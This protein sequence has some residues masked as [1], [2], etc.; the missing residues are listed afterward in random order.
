MRFDE[1]AHCYAE[2]AYVQREMADW[3][4]EWLDP[5]VSA[6]CHAL[7]YGAGEG[8]FTRRAAPYF[9]HLT[10][11]DVAPRMVEQG[12]QAAPEADW[13]VGDAWTGFG[14]DESVDYVVSSSMMQWCPDP[15]EILRL[16]R[17]KLPKGARMLHGLYVEPT[18]K[19]LRALQGEVS[20]PLTWFSAEHWRTAFK[21]AGWQ[22]ERFEAEDRRIVYKNALELMRSLHGV[23]AVR[24]SQMGSSSLRRLIREYD[25]RF[26]AS[27]GGVYANWSFCRVQVIS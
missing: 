3:L 1:R 9:K 16:W 20:S 25:R 6:H 22:V 19:E 21:D 10:S 27:G 17:S 18:L 13:Q 23:G 7:E 5:S 24:R 12:R 8:M 15:V 14:M 2:H 4:A 11:V 26:A